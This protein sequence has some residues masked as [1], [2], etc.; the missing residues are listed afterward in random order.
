ML[1]CH[2]DEATHSRVPQNITW[3]MYVRRYDTLLVYDL[4]GGTFD[5]SLL[6]GWEGILEVREGMGRGNTQGGPAL[7]QMVLI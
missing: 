4:G 5:V 3:S 1:C 7:T 6:E 2:V